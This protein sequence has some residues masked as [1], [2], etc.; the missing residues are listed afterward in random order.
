M[1]EASS[2]GPTN[3]LLASGR[4]ASANK[5]R[6]E[7][8]LVPRPLHGYFLAFTGLFAVIVLAGFSRSFFL[9]VMQGSFARPAVVHV[10]GALFFLW[11]ALLVAQTVLAARRKLKWHR[12]IGSYAGWLILPMLATGA[13]VAALDTRRDYLAG[14][15]DAR[16]T[17]FYGELADLV[18]FGVLAGI[19]MLVRTRPQ[20][21][22]R[23]VLLGSLGL[24]GA[25]VGRIPE[26]GGIYVLEPFIAS[27]L[28]YDLASQRRLHP[29][30][31]GGAAFL[32]TAV[33][34]QGAVGSTDAWLGIAHQVL[35]L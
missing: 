8:R 35:G 26:L 27:M 22:K 16:L 28:A 15:G 30:T 1:P 2:A 6:L 31:L 5:L 32:L 25:A 10:H 24:L 7:R 17:F 11:T 4:S 14:E 3:D 21:H 19:A 12:L 29:A 18:M 23:L 33:Y 13:I 34:S 9:P 20:A